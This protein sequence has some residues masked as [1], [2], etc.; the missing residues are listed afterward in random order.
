MYVDGKYVLSYTEGHQIFVSNDIDTTWTAY[1]LKSKHITKDFSTKKK[2]P[3]SIAESM[4]MFAENPEYRVLIYDKYRNVYYRFA[5]PGIEVKP[6][7]D[8]FKLGEFRRVFSVMIIDK[9]FNL[10]GETL[11]PENTY[12]VNMFFVNEA[13]LWLSTNHVDNPNFEEDAINFELFTLK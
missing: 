7:D 4:K 13:G 12:N 10:I 5:Y 1:C 3:G 11:M 6:D 8:V 9:D 2:K